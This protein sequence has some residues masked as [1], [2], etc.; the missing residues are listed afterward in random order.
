MTDTG[1]GLRAGKV[2]PVPTTHPS[3]PEHRRLIAEAVNH[4][5]AAAFQPY[6]QLDSIEDVDLGDV[7]ADLGLSISVTPYI[8][9]RA[10][11]L[12]TFQLTNGGVA[13]GDATIIVYEN[14]VE[15]V[16]TEQFVGLLGGGY[17]SVAMQALRDLE[18]NTTYVYTVSG[19][20]TPAGDILIGEGSSLSVRLEPRIVATL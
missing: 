2:V 16:Q 15:I 11:V 9:T 12:L 8:P 3:G 18:P 17:K 7:E 14:A 19:Y 20:E 1:S 5:A 10:H 6:T 4:V 13:D